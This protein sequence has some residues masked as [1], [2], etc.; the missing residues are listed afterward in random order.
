MAV[1]IRE[2]A[3]GK[4]EVTI[5]DSVVEVRG[6]SLHVFAQVIA[7]Y[8]AILSYI[9]GGVVDDPLVLLAT[10]PDAAIAVM[11]AGIGHADD[12][13]VVTVLRAWELAQQAKLLNGVL[14]R[15][16]RGAALPFV[17]T[18]MAAAA[19]AAA[20]NNGAAPSPENGPENKETSAP[21]SPS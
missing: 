18:L 19:R 12:A 1:D 21:N 2:I 13:E 10:I 20:P 14:A 8:P 11:A 4:G 7:Q 5:D 6:L 15:T 3:P 9:H 16:F 17:Q